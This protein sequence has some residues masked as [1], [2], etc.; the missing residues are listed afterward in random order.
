[1]ELGPEGAR[2]SHIGVPMWLYLAQNFGS[3]N[4]LKLNLALQVVK[5]IP[6]LRS[7]DRS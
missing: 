1:M 4:I 2:Y 5:K 6:L 7:E 3:L